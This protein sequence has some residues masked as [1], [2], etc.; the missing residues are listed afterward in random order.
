[1][2]EIEYSLTVDVDALVGAIGNLVDNAIDATSNNDPII[3]NFSADNNKSY[4]VIDVK[5]NGQGIKKEYQKDLFEPFYTTKSHGNG[6]GLSIVHG[7][8]IDHQGT[9]SV[10]STYGQGSCFRI[11]LPMVVLERASSKYG[12]PVRASFGQSNQGVVGGY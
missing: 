11:E 3:V 9:I 7:V 6:L 5:D 12:G 1:M 8:V 10:D 4:L 2:N